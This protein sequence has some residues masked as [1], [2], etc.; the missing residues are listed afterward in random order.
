MQRKNYY[1]TRWLRTDDRA[2]KVG[3]QEKLDKLIYYKLWLTALINAKF[4]ID[5]GKKIIDRINDHQNKIYG[6]CPSSEI[7]YDAEI[8]NRLY[9]DK[10]LID[11]IKRTIDAATGLIDGMYS[12]N[13]SNSDYMSVDNQFR[14]DL[15]SMEIARGE[16]KYNRNT[17]EDYLKPVPSY[18]TATSRKFK[19]DQLFTFATEVNEGFYPAHIIVSLLNLNKDLINT[20]DSNGYTPLDIAVAFRNQR[21]ITVFQ[22]FGGVCNNQKNAEILQTLAPKNPAPSAPPMDKLDASNTLGVQPELASAPEQTIYES[23]PNMAA[24]GANDSP[25]PSRLFTKP[26]QAKEPDIAKEE[27]E[28]KP[29]KEMK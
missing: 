4:A 28:M 8:I 22:E 20:V 18:D 26:E 14:K 17:I 27:S 13:K 16:I 9:V 25:N 21:A 10:S 23:N 12:K 29:G 2:Q 3:L 5:E 6:S 19:T 1:P 24:K 15:P 11:A 7:P